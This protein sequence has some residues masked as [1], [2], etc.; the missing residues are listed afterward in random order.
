M[1]DGGRGERSPPGAQARAGGRRG[2]SNIASAS[3]RVR[4]PL[5]I[6]APSITVDRGRGRPKGAARG[7]APFAGGGRAGALL[8]EPEVAVT[9]LGSAGWAAGG[10]GTASLVALSRLAQRPGNKAGA[11]G[12]VRDEHK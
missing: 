7:E 6:P 1:N 8:V 11:S 4:R 10:G 2:A 12:G 5:P 3:W 9:L